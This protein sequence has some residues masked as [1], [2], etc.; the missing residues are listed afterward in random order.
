MFASRGW[1]DEEWREAR[2]RLLEQRLLKDDSR[3]KDAGGALRAEVERRTDDVAAAPWR[4][5]GE[6]ERERLVELPG[7]L[8]VAVIGSGPLTSETTPGIGKV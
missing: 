6:E 2:Q 7:P 5:L 4:E 8:W 1:S 3:T